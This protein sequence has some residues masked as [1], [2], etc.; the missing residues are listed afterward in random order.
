MNTYEFTFLVEDAKAVTALEKALESFSGKKL[1]ENA[2]GKRL[3]AYP[4]DKVTGAEYFTWNI[5]IGIKELE[6]FKQ[7][8]NYDK[9]VLRYLILNQEHTPESTPKKAKTE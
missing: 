9:L 5:E 3:L 8:L 4:I 7:K 1:Q 2:W 6:Q